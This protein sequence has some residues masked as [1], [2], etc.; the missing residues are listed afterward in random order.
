MTPEAMYTPN[1]RERR[2]AL[3]LSG[4]TCSSRNRVAW[5]LSMEALMQ[6][7]PKRRDPTHKELLFGACCA[8]DDARKPRPRRKRRRTA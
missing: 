3:I 2:K 4:N 1:E 7:R 5:S 8:A 6:L